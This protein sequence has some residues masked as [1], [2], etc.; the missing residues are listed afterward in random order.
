MDL[1]HGHKEVYA[2]E[3]KDGSRNQRAT[4]YYRV[5]PHRVNL[6]LVGLNIKD[7]DGRQIT[8]AGLTDIRQEL[9]LYDGEIESSFDAGG[10]HYD[11]I[12]AC[13]P[14]RDCVFYRLKSKAL[15]PGMPRLRCAFLYPYR[16]SCRRCC[17]LVRLCTAYLKKSQRRAILCCDRAQYGFYSLLYHCALGG[18]ASFAAF[19]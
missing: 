15:Q 18:R 16:P 14:G 7:K 5:N 19:G 12:T 11:I 13:M 8:A 3:Y 4:Q 6:G 1:G 2:V 10:N 17:R 9:K